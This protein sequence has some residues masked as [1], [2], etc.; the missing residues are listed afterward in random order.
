MGP[1][2]KELIQGLDLVAH[3]G[4]AIAAPEVMVPV[5]AYESIAGQ[6]FFTGQSLSAG[7]RAVSALGA[8]IPGAAQE[9]EFAETLEQMASSEKSATQAVETGVQEYGQGSNWTTRSAEDVN[10]EFVSPDPANLK[11]SL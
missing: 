7:Q 3:V 10:A 2:G 11:T 9:E 6:D 5:M 8:I 1:A 4:L